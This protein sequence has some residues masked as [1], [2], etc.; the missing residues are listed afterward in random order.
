[1]NWLLELLFGCTHD[2]VTWPQHGR[3][4]C[5]DCGSFRFYPAI[6]AKPSRWYPAK[7]ERA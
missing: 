6:G 1:M 5:I 7:K 3:Q 2:H 4:S